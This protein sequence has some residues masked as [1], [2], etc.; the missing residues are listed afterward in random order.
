MRWD[1]RVEVWRQPD[2]YWRWEYVR[3]ADGS[4]GEV[5]LLANMAYE[6]RE[7]ACRSAAAA[8]AGVPIHDAPRRGASGRGGAR[9][10]A[11]AVLLAAVAVTVWRL[12]RALSRRAVRRA[13]GAPARR[14]DARAG[15]AG[16]TAGVC[17]SRRAGRR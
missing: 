13:A 10:M 9:R 12:Q 3:P 4:S 2:G 7:E 15:R 14:R 6:D 1:D 17:A 16:G 11:R 8:Y 5:R